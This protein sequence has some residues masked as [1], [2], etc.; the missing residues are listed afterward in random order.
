LTNGPGNKLSEKEKWLLAY[1]DGSDK[2]Q[3]VNNLGKESSTRSYGELA[4]IGKATVAKE[5]CRY[6][7]LGPPDE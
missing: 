7:N 1:L 6:L 4:C 2:S 3:L 5:V